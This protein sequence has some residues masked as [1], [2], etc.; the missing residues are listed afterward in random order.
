MQSTQPLTAPAARGRRLDTSPDAFGELRPTPPGDPEVLRERLEEDGYLFVP[1][2][3]DREEVHAGRMDLLERIAEHGALDPDHPLEQ[4]VLRPGAVDL[5]LRQDYPASSAALTNVLRGERMMGFFAGLLEGAARCYDFIWLRNQARTYGIE[6][7][8]DLVF[9]SRGTPDVLTCWTPFGD[10]PLGGGGL[11]LLEGSHRT[12]RTRLADYLRQDVDTYCE[13]GPNAEAVRTGAM[14]WEHWDRPA[15]GRDWGG[16]ITENAVALR[17]QWGGRWLTA[18]EFRMG[19]VLVFT[20]RTVHAGTDN[21][22]PFVRLS[23]DSRY[24]RA[25]APVDER[26]VVGEHGEAP[27]GHGLGAKLGKIC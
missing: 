9:M 15:A 6:P 27:V 12:S 25:D 17:E 13:N 1:G 7:H 5:G 11:M 14:R 10:I 22:T 2:V 19:D 8:C 26:W 24:Q 21:E 20:M 16:E 4:G 3:L 18:P 23:T